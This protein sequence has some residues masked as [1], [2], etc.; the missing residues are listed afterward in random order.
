MRALVSQFT[1]FGLV[2]LVG[3]G[4]DLLVFNV[5]RV[6]VLDPEVVVHGALWAKVI[7]TTLAI[8][9]NWLG[10]RHWTF[11][12]NRR[13][14]WWREG[15]EFGLVSLGGMA[16]SL[17]CLWFSHYVLGFTSLLADNIANNVFGLALGTAF[18]FTFYRLWVFKG[19]ELASESPIQTPAQIP[20]Q[21]PAQIP[22]ASSRLPESTAP[23]A[24]AQQPG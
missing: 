12:Q 23:A 21:T 2:G 20:T 24:S 14:H 11:R 15:I 19:R 6:T 10:N 22:T 3:L 8:I 16:I 17:F 18:R 13:Q 1:R 9:T 4:V 5:L 7:S